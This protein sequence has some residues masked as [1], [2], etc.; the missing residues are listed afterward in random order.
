MSEEGET[1]KTFGQSV[2]SLIDLD[3]IRLSRIAETAQYAAIYAILA[4]FVGVGL[5]MLCA[6][7]YPVKD[8]VIETW[9]QFWGTAGVV[10]LQVIISAVMVFYMRKVAQLFPLILNFCPSRYKVGYH[11][12]ERVGEIAIA[13]VFV[14]AMS[15]LLKNM[16]RMRF[17]LGSS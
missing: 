9:P 16:D 7:I 1:Q 5:D 8:G 14:G 17:F 13:L 10:L 3:T 12:P 2:W 6:K 11:V 15:T 4:L